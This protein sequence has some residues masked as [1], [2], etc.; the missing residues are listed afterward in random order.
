MRSFRRPEYSLFGLTRAPPLT[1]EGPMQTLVIDG[2]RPVRCAFRLRL[3]HF[4]EQHGHTVA[5]AATGGRPP[6]GAEA[7]QP[8]IILVL[9]LG[10]AGVDALE[11]CHQLRE[12]TRAPVIVLSIHA[13]AGHKIAAFECGADE[14][15]TRPFNLAEL[16]ARMQALLR[17]SGC[18]GAMAAAPFSAGALQIDFDRR[19]VTRSG[20]EL[21]LTPI[22]FELLRYL[23]LNADR[24][25]THAELLARVWGKQRCEDSHTLRVHIAN[26]RNKIEPD[27]AHPQFLRTEPRLGYRFCTSG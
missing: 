13:G 10:N 8:D 22:E 5:R 18:T 25:L 1:G 23:T 2:E 6:D 11:A 3:T 26:L 27:P 9:D 21:R 14:Y 4:L 17:R 20:E 19:R 16:L 15:L 12:W 7:D 24:S